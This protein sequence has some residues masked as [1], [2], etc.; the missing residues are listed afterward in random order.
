MALID[1]LLERYKTRAAFVTP[2]PPIPSE[3]ILPKPRIPSGMLP[4][5]KVPPPVTQPPVYYPIVPSPPEPAPAPTPTPPYI[6][7]APPV[8]APISGGGVPEWFGQL[9]DI[10]QLVPR[11]IDIPGVTV[12]EVAMPTYR[13]M[14]LTGAQVRAQALARLLDISPEEE[15]AAIEKLTAPGMRQFEEE[16]LPLTRGRFLETGTAW[17]TMRSRAEAGAAT[18]LAERLA[19]MGEQYRLQRR[20]QA[21]GA[22]GI[23]LEEA[24]GAVTTGLTRYGMEM[25]PALQTQLLG[26]Q[27]LL[28][29]QQLGGTAAMEAQ[30]LLVQA[31]VAREQI[32]AQLLATPFE[33]ITSY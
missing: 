13:P 9:G 22:A 12:P 25:Q 31:R 15:A 2:P 28:Q 32:L 26:T 21:M 17:S 14:E 23:S 19:A 6:P 3:P 16:I 5:V 30:R 7:P 11:P 8:T 27:A 1:E 4:G 18:D 29:T 10:G 24:L 20:T 33:D